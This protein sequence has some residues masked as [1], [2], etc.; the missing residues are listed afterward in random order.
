MFRSI[1]IQSR[2]VDYILHAAPSSPNPQLLVLFADAL[3]QARALDEEFKQ[4]GK[5]KG[6]LHGVPISVKDLFNIAGYD[7]CIGFST[8]CDKPADVDA[9]IVQAVKKAGGVILCK[10][11]VSPLVI[12]ARSYRFLCLD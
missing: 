7:S 10:V 4:T 3:D 8:W 5:V 12:A 6:P 9:S 1:L 2:K 11:F